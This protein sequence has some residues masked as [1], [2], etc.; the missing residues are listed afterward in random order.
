M[1]PGVEALLE[2]ARAGVTRLTPQET[3]QAATR[4][5][6]VIDIRTDTQRQEQGDL[7]GV[8]VIDR[9]VLEWRLDPASDARIPEAT[10]YD[11]EVVVVC[12]QG[13]S[14]S[15]AAASLRALGLHR[16]TDTV[17]GVEGWR[18]AGLP[19][20]DRPADVRR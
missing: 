2:Q 3:V 16:A 18:A 15:L 5:A 17:G 19:L 11:I 14:S 7:P 9:T 12:R 4:G 13:Y 6:L 8:I 1:S 20:S 10:G